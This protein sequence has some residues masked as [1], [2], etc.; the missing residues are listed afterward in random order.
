MPKCIQN[1]KSSNNETLNS[2]PRP[3]SSL[4]PI[5]CSLYLI[6]C[7]LYPIL[8]I[9]Q[10]ISNLHTKILIISYNKIKNQRFK[11]EIFIYIVKKFSWG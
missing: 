7:S 6:L 9:F 4:Y 2:I 10:I 8:S 1:Q 11:S 3:N 5:L